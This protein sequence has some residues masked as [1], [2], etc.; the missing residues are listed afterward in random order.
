MG[1]RCDDRALGGAAV[2]LR[3]DDRA[4]G[5]AAVGLRCDDRALG[6]AAVGLRCDGRA[7]GAAAVGLRCLHALPERNFRRHD[8]ARQGVLSARAP[9]ALC[10]PRPVKLSAARGASEIGWGGRFSPE[11]RV[12]A[13]REVLIVTK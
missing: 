12:V 9:C 6:G 11:K 7:L 1:L 10:L 13:P 4:L 3:C 2:G 5:A 8:D